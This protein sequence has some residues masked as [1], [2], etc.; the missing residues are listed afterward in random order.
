MSNA[1]KFYIDG[2]WV[3][4]I[5]KETLAVINPATEET[6]ETI[7]MG[8]ASDVDR[9]VAAARKAFDSYSL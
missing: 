7:A 4:P 2:A 6:V 9:A 5:S 3:D 1:K 8:S